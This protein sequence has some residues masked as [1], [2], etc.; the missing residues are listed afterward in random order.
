M[1]MEV[2]PF[3]RLHVQKQLV[4]ARVPLVFTF[5]NTSQS[6][7][8]TLHTQVNTMG[9]SL[10]LSILIASLTYFHCVEVASKLSGCSSIQPIRQSTFAPAVFVGIEA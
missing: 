6:S 7:Q 5:I 1:P 8:P 9:T 2:S 10:P 4:L 3:V